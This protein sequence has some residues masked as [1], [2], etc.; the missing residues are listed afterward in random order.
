MTSQERVR[1]TYEF[2]PVDHLPRREFYI[3]SEALAKWKEQG[4]PDDWQERNLFQFDPG[5]SV[6][7]GANLGWCEPPFLPAYEDKVIAVE[8]DHE[9]IQDYAGRL[10]KVFKGRRHGFMPDYLKHPVSN[11]RDWEEEVAPRLD[12]ETPGR[13]AGLDEACERARQEQAANGTFVVQG[14]IGGYMYL[15]ALMGPE[16]VLY[17][18]LDQPDLI[19][20]MMQRWLAMNDTAL[21]KIQARVELDELDLAEDICYRSGLLISPDMVREFLLPYYQELVGRARRRQSRR[22]YLSVDTDGYAPAA[23]PLYLEAG[24]DI[25]TPFEVASGCDVVEIGRQYPDLILLGGIDKRVLAAGPEAI[26]A[27]LQHILPPM[28]ARGGYI[29]T[30]DHGVPDNVSFESYVYYRRRMCELDR[31]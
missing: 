20:A 22:I 30:C 31:G 6:A 11:R 27:H 26:E 14:F 15:R 8:G 9:I 13:W 12:P 1:A 24:M 17:A 10:L 18:F 2:R 21:Q 29:P 4:L 19:H 3:W 5:H 23:I 7:A 16:D 28:V 25:M